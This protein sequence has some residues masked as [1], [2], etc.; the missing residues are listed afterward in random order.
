LWEVER[1]LRK[2]GR[3]LEAAMERSIRREIGRICLYREQGRNYREDIFWQG[4][5]KCVVV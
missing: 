5:G 4:G 3:F 1:P 2:V